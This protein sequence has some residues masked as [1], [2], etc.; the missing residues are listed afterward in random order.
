V[1][2]SCVAK[3]CRGGYENADTRRSIHRSPYLETIKGHYNTATN[4]TQN[5]KER[6]PHQ[7][8]SGAL[9]HKDTAKLVKCC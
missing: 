3:D 9:F 5:N 7:Y 1:A 8:H 2:D 4:G 6:K